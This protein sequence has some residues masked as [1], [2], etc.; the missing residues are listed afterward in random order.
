MATSLRERGYK[1]RLIAPEMH[2]AMVAQAGIPFHGTVVDP[3][4]LD[5]K[6]LWHPLRGFAVVW[7]AV[8][9]GLRELPGLLRTLAQTDASRLAATPPL[10]PPVLPPLPPLLLPPSRSC[11]IIAHPLALPDAVLVRDGWN[12]SSTSDPVLPAK[13][14]PDAQLPAP[15]VPGHALGTVRV[16]A[17]YLAPSNIPTVHDPLILGPWPVPR[18][19]PHGVRRWLWRQISAHVIDPVALPDINADRTA[20]H[21]PPIASLFD[22]MRT[23]PDLSVT[24][25]PAWF[26]PAKP[27]WPQPLVSGDFALF[28]PNPLLQFT[29]ELKDF[30]DGGAAP[31]IFTHGTGNRQA[32]QFF[33]H[34]VEA[35]LALGRRAIFLTPHRDQIA[36]QLPPH[37]LW[38]SYLPLR[39]CL[40]H[41]ALV[42]HHGGIGTTAEA[43][44][45]RVRQ[46]IVPLAFDQFDNGARVVAL[47]AG[48]MLAYRRLTTQ[49]LVAE[50]AVLLDPGAGPL[51]PPGLSHQAWD[52]MMAAIVEQG[53]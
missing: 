49:R 5:D 3:A 31:I 12:R 2:A 9:P 48:R 13:H 41:A 22:F 36:A 19:V 8:R 33:M 47:G 34:A 52:D 29:A 20:A 35:T 40:P 21:L 18:W 11:V 1:V 53:N 23:A 42:V 15:T 4:V 30:I 45:A 44:R 10:S 32:Q 43:L 24:L 14:S 50:L 7:K 38:Q 37:V 6:H 27:D 51:P 28:D 46:L 39:R 25:F 17:A 16:V 26:G